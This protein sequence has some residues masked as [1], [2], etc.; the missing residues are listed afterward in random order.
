MLTIKE[1]NELIKRLKEVPQT[2]IV[3]TFTVI[4]EN[5]K[6]NHQFIDP[7]FNEVMTLSSA[8]IARIKSIEKLNEYLLS[9]GKAM[10][11]YMTEWSK[12][13][14]YLFE[15]EKNLNN[16]MMRS[17]IMNKNQIRHCT[18]NKEIESIL[19]SA[20]KELEKMKETYDTA[21]VYFEAISSFLPVLQ[22]L[23]NDLKYIIQ[24]RMR[25]YNIDLNNKGKMS[26]FNR[27]R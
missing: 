25:E 5:L 21:K 8:E 6:I 26:G 7:S 15:L 18:T 13:K 23:E 20:D 10:A 11:S 14:I 12:R 3:K 24:M 16:R 17:R 27:T 22:S 19:Y 9:I 1:Q 2:I 4:L